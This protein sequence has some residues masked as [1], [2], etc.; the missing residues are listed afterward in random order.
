MRSSPKPVTL[1]QIARASSSAAM[2]SSPPKTVTTSRSVGML[3]TLREELP[4]E[5]DRVLLEV[6]AEGEVAEHLE[7]RVVARGDADVLE[8]VV[9]AADADALLARGRAACRAA[10]R[11]R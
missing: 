11:G 3:E 4:G 2:P 5:R 6:V 1:R 7:E 8:V 10:S 9:L